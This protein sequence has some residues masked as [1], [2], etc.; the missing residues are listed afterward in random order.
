MENKEGYL[1]FISSESYKNQLDIWYRAYNIS[2]EKTELFYD[3]LVSL[4]DLVEET[5]LGMDVVIL[6]EDQKNHFTWCWDKTI[7][8]F[9]KEKI[10]FKER[11]G[12]Y[13][14]FWNFFYEAYYFAQNDD[15]QIR[16]KEYFYKLFDFKH[17]KSRSELDMLTEIYK[18]FDQ[19]LKK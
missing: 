2:R 15:N 3:F 1:E 18:L 6:E 19:N 5:Y 4:Y 9:N 7:D 14:Y 16:I 12:C 8:S 11:S 17:R 13:E 10:Y